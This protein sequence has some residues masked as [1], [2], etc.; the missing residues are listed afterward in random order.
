MALSTCTRCGQAA[1]G[2]GATAGDGECERTGVD[3]GSFDHC[4]IH[5]ASPAWITTA[6]PSRPVVN[7]LVVTTCVRNPNVLRCCA[8]KTA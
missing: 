6:I 4:S 3:A 8:N 2:R 1:S 7:G 5:A